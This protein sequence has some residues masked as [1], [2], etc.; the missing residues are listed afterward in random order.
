MLSSV[1]VTVEA[2]LLLAIVVVGLPMDRGKAKQHN[3]GAK[4]SRLHH[5]HE[6]GGNGEWRGERQQGTVDQG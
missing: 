3:E 5:R 6:G 1:L 2:V 4:S